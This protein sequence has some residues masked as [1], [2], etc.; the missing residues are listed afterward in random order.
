MST[1]NSDHHISN[2]SKAEFRQRMG[3]LDWDIQPRRDLWPDISS[4]IRF[5][6]K[7]KQHTPNSEANSEARTN[8][9]WLPFAVAASTVFAV[10]CL[11]FSAMSYQYAQDAEK[12]NAVLVEYQQAQL[13]LIDQQH[14]MVRVQFA[15]LLEEQ[16]DSLNPAFVTEVSTLM[17]NIDQAASEIKN[18]L[19]TQPN[20][21]SYTFMLV[22]T[23]QQELN[24]LNKV[25]SNKGV[26]I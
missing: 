17:M 21:P 25:K 19:V 12:Q 9:P 4:K 7:R 22:S 20:N 15:R 18:A 6:D 8:K 10:V 1:D 11:M 23:Y 2:A 14:R 16:S 5:A 3:E 13:E 26:S 24:L